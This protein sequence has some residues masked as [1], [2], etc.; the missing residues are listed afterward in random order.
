[1]K[2][3][4]LTQTSSSNVLVDVP[5]L[6]ATVEYPIAQPFLSAYTDLIKYMYT[7]FHSTFKS[8]K[9]FFDHDFQTLR[10][11]RSIS[12]KHICWEMVVMFVIA[13]MR[14]KP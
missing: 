7:R 14:N 3:K 8:P 6:C 4:A 9:V 11:V 12:V 10:G 2:S 5:D 13:G 1:M